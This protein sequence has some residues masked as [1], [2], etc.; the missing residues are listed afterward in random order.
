MFSFI[1]Q[2]LI[3]LLKRKVITLRAKYYFNLLLINNNFGSFFN[4]I[5]IRSSLNNSSVNSKRFD[6]NHVL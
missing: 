5:S 1:K 6:T 4:D 2:H 3:A